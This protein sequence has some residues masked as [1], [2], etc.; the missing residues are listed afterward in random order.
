MCA[1]AMGS[2]ALHCWDSSGHLVPCGSVVSPRPLQV[3]FMLKQQKA[4]S[5]IKGIAVVHFPVGV[6]P[7]L[8]L[9]Q[10]KELYFTA[11]AGF[12]V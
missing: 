10:E 1:A 6:K 2:S 4:V 7:F 5:S 3:P 8:L 9:E 12:I 11:G